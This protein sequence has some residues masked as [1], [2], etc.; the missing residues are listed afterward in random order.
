MCN[1]RAR[2]LQRG[3]E[4]G[5]LVSGEAVQ[6]K[7]RMNTMLL[8]LDLYSHHSDAFTKLIWFIAI[9]DCRTEPLNQSI[10]I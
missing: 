8:F 5:T 6:T 2:F 10:V 4:K 9:K 3:E 7:E 1:S